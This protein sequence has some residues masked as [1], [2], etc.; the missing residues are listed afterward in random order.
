VRRIVADTDAAGPDGV[1]PGEHHR[2]SRGLDRDR[3]VVERSVAGAAIVEI[4]RLYGYVSP[5]PA[6][7][8]V[9]RALDLLVPQLDTELQRRLDVARLDRLLA[10]W[11]E[12]ATDDPVAARLVLDVL[13]TKSRVRG[14]EPSGLSGGDADITGTLRS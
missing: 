1:S 10:A 4:G 9:E 5:G 13:V 2:G 14:D 7:R 6:I 8:L 12:R 11:W 3:D